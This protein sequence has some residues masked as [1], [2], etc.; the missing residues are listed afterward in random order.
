MQTTIQAHTHTHPRPLPHIQAGERSRAVIAIPIGSTLKVMWAHKTRVAALRTMKPISSQRN[1]VSRWR[2][3]AAELNPLVSDMHH[4]MP[5]RSSAC[6]LDAAS[7][8]RMGPPSSSQPHLH[9]PVFSS[10]AILKSRGDACGSLSGR[11]VACQC[12]PTPQPPC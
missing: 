9:V 6:C 8:T 4:S 5:I 11:P 7:L 12:R 3:R 2:T 10:L 1:V